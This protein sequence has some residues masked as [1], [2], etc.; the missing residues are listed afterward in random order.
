MFPHLSPQPVSVSG[1]FLMSRMVGVIAMAGAMRLVQ[2]LRSIRTFEIMALAGNA[3]PRNSHDQQGEKFHRALHS[4]S[5]RKRNPQGRIR[6]TAP[7]LPPRIGSALMKTLFCYS[8]LLLA[9]LRSALVE[10]GPIVHWN[11]D[12]TKSCRIVWIER[13]DQVGEEGKWAIGPA[14]FGY[15][16]DD[17]TTIF[18]KMQDRFS[19]LAIRREVKL[20]PDTDPNAE[21]VLR[22]TYDDGFIAWLDGREIARRNVVSKD[23]KTRAEKSHEAGRWEEILVGKAHR[24]LGPEAKVLALRG[25]NIEPGSSDFTLHAALVAQKDKKE[26]PVIS[27]GEAWEYLANAE[28]EAG[29]RSRVLNLKAPS[30]ADK[31]FTLRHRAA[32]QSEWIPAAVVSRS[33]AGSEHRVFHAE[34]KNLPA[35]RDI[36]FE[37]AGESAAA[38]EP[39]SF[40][41][42][43][44][45]AAPIRFI[46]GGDVYHA[47]EPM[48]QMN[49]R[50]GEEDP[51]F[52]LIGGDLAYA[53]DVAL[54]RWFHYIESWADNAR[55]PDGRLVPK[56]VA[57]GNHEALG[58][59]YHP[60]DAPGPDAARMFY[61][62]FNFPVKDN[63]T[64]VVDFGSWLS[65]VM[66]DSGH[67]RT[68]AA[69]TDWLE[70]ALTERRGVPNLFVAYHRPAWGSGTK[71]DAVEIQREWCP[72]IE[73]HR[74][75]AVFEYDHHVFCRTHPI[76]GGVVDETHG[77]PYLGSG[78]WSVT[79]RLI[80]PA[81][82]RKRPWVA[83]A[84]PVNHIY[85]VE[86]KEHGYTATAK[87]IAGNVIDRSER[88]WKR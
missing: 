30:P 24:F 19:S 40:R 31:S 58:A 33:L 84:L 67:T 5:P 61:S 44:A 57:I 16:D 81:E 23:G 35:G 4:H 41:M 39:Y 48:N 79:P 52:A 17:D 9:P 62:I 60:N 56:V 10:Y 2:L 68:I 36:Q 77:V 42:P 66:L 25:F 70:R 11:Q 74:A 14:G 46:T 15:G 80:D 54:D 69:Q 83:A 64:H 6:L 53:N 50:A 73:R 59:G 34:L 20:P 75:T 43:P 1:R 12:P 32:G 3:K 76:K 87:D 63:A 26:W 78:S 13:A 82:L 8:L 88:S 45:K 28:P 38:S 7:A 86:T 18:G 72:V 27:A 22:V 21:L 71:D 29:W 55:T 49:R 51:L 37:I 65:L 47:R 85:I